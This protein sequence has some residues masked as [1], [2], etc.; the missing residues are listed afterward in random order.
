MRILTVLHNRNLEED[1]SWRI[2]D[3]TSPSTQ[4]LPSFSLC[5]LQCVDFV[6]RLPLSWSQE[7]IALNGATAPAIVTSLYHNVLFK[8]KE[9]LIRTTPNLK[10]SPHVRESRIGSQTH[11]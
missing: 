10:I 4:V 7:E 6:F 9:I 3:L 8:I 2:P 1:A 5:H 11:P